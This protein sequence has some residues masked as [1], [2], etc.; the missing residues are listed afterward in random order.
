M[1]GAGNPK[2]VVYLFGAGATQA[3]AS[4]RGGE[5]I[6]MLMKDSDSLGDGISKRVLKKAG[7]DVL[8]D[9]P[10]D[11]KIDIEKLISLLANTGI[12]KYEGEAEKLRKLYFREILDG[13]SKTGVLYE[14]KLAIALLE[15]HKNEEYRDK[16]EVLSCIISLNH[17][18][19]FQTAMKKVYS[20]LNLGFK[21]ESKY[22]K[23]SAN[24]E[25]PMLI[26]LHGAFNWLNGL[27]I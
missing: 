2:K 19:L 12:E 1:A 10:K 15:M 26:H 27:P 6:N 20:A 24:H 18:N 21:C 9:L 4:F 22:Y 3:E 25:I 5:K 8:L 23:I 16:I 17:D 14:P 11:G 7:T 13:L